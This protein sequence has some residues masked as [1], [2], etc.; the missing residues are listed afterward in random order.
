MKK[1][2]PR[3]FIAILIIII[4]VTSFTLTTKMYP[5]FADNSQAKIFTMV[6]FLI[7]LLVL[8]L[9]VRYKPFAK[10][11]SSLLI[12]DDVN[13]AFYGIGLFFL[14][15]FGPLTLFNYVNQR[16]QRSPIINV[17][18]QISA[19]NKYIGRGGWVFYSVSFP[20]FESTQTLRGGYLYSLVEVGDKINVKM[21][22]GRLGKFYALELEILKNKYHYN[23]AGKY[24]I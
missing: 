19:K 6:S 11:L 12:K 8:L 15:F 20:I 3:V 14:I 1:L 7:F 23:L 2:L 18:T 17:E 24:L 16:E 22:R 21:K 10:W 13:L 9:A 4:F 5:T